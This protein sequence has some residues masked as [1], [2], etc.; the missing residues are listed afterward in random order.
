MTGRTIS[1]HRPDTVTPRADA[2]GVRILRILARRGGIVPRV[3]VEGIVG[4]PA[5]CRKPHA[6]QCCMWLTRCQVNATVTG[7]G[8]PPKW[9]QARRLNSDWI[10]WKRQRLALSQG[11]LAQRA[12]CSRPSIVNIEQG[13]QRP[14]PELSER[15]NEVLS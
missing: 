7:M 6:A 15:I 5:P 9:T 8:Q 10:R 4:L 3:G 2:E 14:T 11:E 1:K 12:G 13:R